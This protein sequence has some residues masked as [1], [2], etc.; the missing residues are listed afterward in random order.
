MNNDSEIFVEEYQMDTSYVE[1][2]KEGLITGKVTEEPSEENPVEARY[3][4]FLQVFMIIILLTILMGTILVAIYSPRDGKLLMAPTFFNG[5][6]DFYPTVLLVSFDGF[7]ADYLDRN[8]TPTLN[9]LSKPISFYVQNGIK[10]EYMIPSFPSVTFPN[11]YTII[12]GLYP[13]SHGIVGNEFYDPDLDDDFYYTNPNKSWDSK[14]WGGEPIWVT[15][16]KQGQK[17]G[18]SQWVGTSSIIKGYTPTY[19]YPY[20][21]NVTI[22]E[23]VNQIMNWLDLPLSERPT[24]LA[25]Y[26]SEVD[27]AGHKF[28]PD[29]VGVNDSLKY[30]D[31]FALSLLEGLVS[32]HGM[33]QTVSSNQIFLDNVFDVSKV[34]P[35]ECRPL[36]GIRPYN[37]SDINDIYLSLKDASQNQP[38][39][40]YLRDEIPERF[41]FRASHRIAPIFCIPPVGWILSTHRDFGNSSPKGMHGYD[42]LEPEMRG[43]FLASGPTFKEIASK[44]K[45]NVVKS[46]F[47]IEVYNIVA[48]ILNLTPAENNGTVGGILWN[49]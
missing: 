43:I 5:S 38:W 10:A 13:E 44:K 41:H 11:H 8:I 28:G 29:S 42:N 40:C 14:W 23:K 33:A 4:F 2:E 25:A 45:T 18:V 12:T 7:R 3:K 31:N 47:N 17:S 30:V 35:I 6:H 37:D 24:F 32:D 49:D 15:T 21:P 39:N 36:A 48:K 1:Q 46:F 34:R 27:S 19:H 26:A 22:E 16:V 20:T 9:K